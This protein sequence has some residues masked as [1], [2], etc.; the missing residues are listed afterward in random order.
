MRVSAA[1]LPRA[2]GSRLRR[3]GCST[4]STRC[5]PFPPWLRAD[6]GRVPY[7]DRDPLFLSKLHTL[8]HAFA[9]TVCHRTPKADPAAYFSQRKEP[10]APYSRGTPSPP[11]Q[12][13]GPLSAPAPR[14]SLL[15]AEGRSQQGP[16]RKCV[17]QS[18]RPSP[19]SVRAS[20]FGESLRHLP[21]ARKP[22]NRGERDVAEPRF[23]FGTTQHA[24]PF[25][26]R[27]AKSLPT[28]APLTAISHRAVWR[29][30]KPAGVAASLSVVRERRGGRDGLGVRLPRVL[31]TSVYYAAEPSHRRAMTD[32][33]LPRTGASKIS[34]LQEPTGSLGS[35]P[36]SAEAFAAEGGTVCTDRQR[37][38]RIASSMTD[39]R[40]FSPFLSYLAAPRKCRVSFLRA[41]TVG[42][43]LGRRFGNERLRLRPT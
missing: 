42:R 17:Q 5:L 20:S 24:P 43:A 22:A 31:G 11:G 33:A 12:C 35:S 26:R 30:Q 36:K 13:Q 23:P 2:G 7:P 18:G 40:R 9:S 41:R 14:T 19:S 8:A 34:R 28:S 1:T 29:D 32:R 38:R 10:G 37:T 4:P 16:G 39:R 6:H 25:P 21:K 27:R 3:A 15:E